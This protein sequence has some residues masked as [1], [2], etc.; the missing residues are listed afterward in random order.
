MR[1]RTLVFGWVLA[2]HQMGAGL[3]VFLG[4]M[5]RDAFGSHGP[6][7]VASGGLC[8]VAA[9]MALVIRRCPETAGTA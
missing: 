9:L 1:D 8:A 4:G 6:V 2:S 3:V 7:W 5:A